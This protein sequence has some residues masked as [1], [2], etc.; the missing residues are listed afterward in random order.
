MNC[1]KNNTDNF[2]SA[3]LFAV[4][5]FFLISFA[6]NEKKESIINP[7]SSICLFIDIHSSTQAVIP[8]GIDLPICATFKDENLIIL[9]Q[10]FISDFSINL[11]IDESFSA[12]QEKHLVIKPI[13]N[14]VIRRLVFNDPEPGDFVSFC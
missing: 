6:G 11:R 7:N 13:F 10:S 4:L 3:I 9:N 1:S 14:K 12:A 8:A 5:A 2:R